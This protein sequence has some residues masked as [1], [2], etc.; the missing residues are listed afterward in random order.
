M[1]NVLINAYACN[2][3]WGSEQGIGWNWSI[4][5]AKYCQVIVITEG[6]FKSNIEEALAELPQKENIRFIYNNVADDVRKMCWNQGDWRFYFYYRQWQK[7]TLEIAKEICRKEKIDVIHQLNMQ[8][9]REPGLLWKIKG[10]KYFWGPVGG[11]GNMPLV[12]LREESLKK[13]GFFLLKNIINTIQYKHQPNVKHAVQRADALIASTPKEQL[14][15]KEVYHKD[16]YFINDTGCGISDNSHDWKRNDNAP[17][18]LI[19]VAKFDVR[20]QLSLAI[21]VIAELKEL[22]VQLNIFGGGANEDYYRSL[23]KELGVEDKCIFH[24]IVP[25]DTVLKKMLSA[26]IFFFTSVKEDSSTVI[27]EAIG[28]RLPIVC[29]DTCGFGPIVDE[30]IGR[31]VKIT[32]PQQSVKDFAEK[33]EYLY[34]NREVL[35]RMSENCQERVEELSWDNKAKKMYELYLNENVNDNVNENENVNKNKNCRELV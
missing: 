10:P 7:K 9:F 16:S 8:G 24:G 14:V 30:S 31:K 25:H 3:K 20:K 21:K 6:E 23:A 17:L 22:N 1:L 15:F 29:F 27:L 4:E 32:N 26:D 18:N 33:I 11:M 5:L 19:W 13:R 12:Y 2:P 28:A 35:V 34:H